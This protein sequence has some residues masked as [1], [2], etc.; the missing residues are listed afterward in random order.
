MI[1]SES[2]NT[3]LAGVEGIKTGCIRCG[4]LPNIDDDGLC[5][6]VH[7]HVFDDLLIP[8]YTTDLNACM[9][10]VE[11]MELVVEIDTYTKTILIR[12]PQPGIVLGARHYETGASAL[13]LSTMLAEIARER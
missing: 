1:N 5:D 2:I 3:T 6:S 7:R 10:V 9:R 12:Q 4:I 11:E 8:D 13:N